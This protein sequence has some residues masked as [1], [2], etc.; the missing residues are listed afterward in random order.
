MNRYRHA[1]YHRMKNLIFYLS[2][3]AKVL[4][5]FLFFL[6]TLGAYSQTCEVTL[7]NDSLI[8]ANNLIVDIYLKATS[9]PFYY[10]SGQFKVKYNKTSILNGGSISGSI[11]PGYSELTNSSQIPTTIYTT[12]S[13]YWRIT[14]EANPTTQAA[15]SQISNL[16]NGTRICRVQL[17]NTAS[18]GAYT[19]NDSLVTTNPY[20]TAIWYAAGDG[21]AVAAT[22]TLVNSN[23]VNPI[24]NGA[25]TVFN[26]TGGGT[27]P[28]AVG[29]DGSQTL[30]VNYILYNGSNPQGS[31]VDGTGS[32][33]SFGNQPV[34]TYTVKA[35]RKATYM[36]QD[37]NGTA[38]VN[39]ACV[40]VTIGT[41]P[42]AKNMCAVTGSASL[43]LTP[44]GSA[45][46]TY[47]WQYYNGATWGNVINGTPAGASYTN[48]TT[49]SLTVSGITNPG[50][51]QYQCFITNCSGVNNATSSAA[52]LTVNPLTVAPTAS[53]GTGA[54]CSQIT[55]N[56]ASSA[57]AT[58]YELDVS[59]S[60][61]FAT[62]VTGYQAL[63]VGNVLTYNVTGLTGG[64]T[65]YYRVRAVN[66]C[67]TSASSNTITYATTP[68]TPAAPAAAAGTGATCSQI[69]A[70]WTASA[71]AL[72]YRLDVSTS[73][74]F[75]TYVT[76]YQD[77]NVLNVV[78][79]NVTGLTGGT[80]YYYRIRAVNACGTSASSSTITYATAPATPA[81]PAANA[82]TGATCSQITANWTASA[83]ALSYRLDV[84]TS[85]TFATYVTGY[86]DLN[87]LNVITYNVTVLIGGTTYYY[88][89]RAVNACGTSA[90]SSTITYATAP[91]T[92][93]APTANAGTG[94]TC[95]QIT[96]NWAASTNATYYELDV[97]TVNTFVTYVTGYQDL[98]V[99]NVLTYN[100]TG[101]T[102][103]TTY[104]YRVRAVNAC[105]TSASSGTI[106]YV[107]APAIPSAPTANAG[108]GAT[109]SQITANWTSSANA[110]YYELDVST[111]NT[112]VTYVTGY[113]DLNVGNVLTYNVTGL[114]GGT[115]YYYR[116]RAVNACGT[117]ANSNVITYAT[118]PG[119][120]VAP[121]ANAGTGATCLQITANWASSA[122]ATSYAL[123]VS[124]VNTFVSYVTG[125]QDLNVGNVLTYN[126]TGLAGG[127]TYYYRVRAINS[128]GNS[129]NSNVITYVTAPSTPAAPVAA[130]GTGATCSQITVNWTASANALSYRLDVSTSNTFVTYVTGYQDLNVLNVI[131][132]NVTGLIGG[133]TYYYRVRAVNACG[134]S[135]S[136]GTITYATAPSTPAAPAAS[137]G[138]G[139]TCS[140]ITAN[141]TSSAN[142][143]SYEL[144]V[145][146]I[147]SFAT[148]VTG[149]Q[150]LNV[151]NV[152]TYNVTGLTGGTTYYYRIRAVNA[153]GT[154]ASSG[155]ITY[156]TTPAIPAAP[157][158][159]AGTGATCL[160]ITANW[161]SSANATYYEL[162]VSTVNTFVTY[163]T[164]YQDLNVGNVVTYNVTGLNGG[165]T[166][167]YR[168]RAVN[169]CGT[170]INSSTIT[171]ATTPGTPAAPVA[172]AGSG[173]TCSQITANWASS[174]NAT[175][176]ALDVSTVNTFVSYVT[177]YQDLNVGNVLTY[178]VTGLTG[179]ITYYYRVRAVN[180][181]GNSVNSNVITYATAPATPTA[182]VANAG[183]GATCSQITAN[184]ASSANATY[185]EL[186]V[187]TVNT[188]AS[189]VTGYQ[190]L[191]VG[192]VVT[193]NVTG[194][195][196]G[197]TYYY[198]VRA[199]NACGTSASSSTITYA[200]APATP[201]AP[202]AIAGS[203]ATCSQI[204]ANWTSSANATSYEL[205]VSTSNTFATYVTGYQDLNVGNVV[206]YNV[207]GLTGSTTY[208]YRV[209]A[210]NA[211]GTSTS[212]STIT[213]ATAPATPAAP[214]ANAG[215]GATCS[216]I[217]ANW[218]SSANATSYE[219]DVSTSNTFATY[220]T[221]YQD[222]NVLN[223]ITYNVTGLTGGTT[224]YYRVRAVN[225]CGTSSN[226]NV[227][228]YATT[229]GTPSQPGT[230]TGTATQC[231]G[232]TSQ[233]YSISP[234]TG[235]TTYTWTVPTGWSI[236]GGTGTTSITVT[237][238]TAGQNGNISVTADN[239]CGTS[240]PRTLG[241]TVS[242][243]TPTQPGTITGT[244]T[245]CPGLTSQVYSISAVTNATTYTWT[246]PTGWSV[247]AGTGTTSITV[248]TGTAG[249][250]GNISVTAG[251][252]CGTSAARTLGVTVSAGTPAQPG[253]ITGITE[254]CPGLTGQAY[255]IS[256]VTGATTYAW[257]VPTGWSITTGAGTTSI[258]VT[259]GST[260]QNGSISVTAGNSCGTS[261]ANT[262]AV[263]V[264]TLSTAPAGVAITNNNTCNG[265][266]KILT[267]AGGNL[268]F[269]A[270]WQWFT[271]SCGG[272][273]AGTGSSIIVDPPAGTST[274]Y[275]V[276][277]SGSCNNTVC[278]SG[279]VVTNPAVGTP[280]T[281][282]PSAT[283][284]CQGSANTNYTS[285]AINAT[286]YN[287]SVTGTGNT[288]S[289]IGTTGTVTWAPGFYG[290][291][292]VSVTANG[293]NGPSS[294]AS[295]T[296]TV[297]QN[298]SA[299]TGSAAQTFCSG[300]LPT[301]AFLTATGT[302]IKW[303]LSSEDG[304]ALSSST[305][306]ATG[307]YYASQTV[308][309]CES[310]SRLAVS[311]TV[312]TT[313]AAPTVGTIT[314]TT[315]ISSTGSVVLSG[316]PSG[317]WTINPG[318][319]TGNTAGTTINNLL[320]GTYNFTVTTNPANCTS[321]ATSNVV[322]N[323]QPVT[324]TPPIVGTITQP[325]C[326]L[327]TG[328]VVLSGLPSSGT[329]TLIRYSGTV[330]TSG[331]G[332]SVSISEL[333]SGSV[334][335]SYNYT[336]TNAAGCTSSLSGNVD[337]N[338]QPPLPSAPV[339]TV[340]CS[341]GYGNAIVTVTS[342]TGSYQYRLDA[343]AFQT[344]TSFTGV[345]NGNHTI[346]VKNSSGCTT[347]GNLFSVSC[348]CANPPAVAL[349]S[350]SGSTCGIT[351]VTVSG[352]TF[353]GGATSVTITEDGSGS[354]SPASATT[355]P[356]NFTYTPVAADAGKVVTITVTTD[357]P[358]GTPCTV[359]T[360]TYKLTVNAIPSA[361]AIGTITQP[362]CNV[363]TGSVVLNGLPSTGT[364]TLTRT[365]GGT[366]TGTGT[367]TTV[368][369]LAA[370]TTYT[371]TVTSAANCTSPVSA[372]VVINPQPETPAPPVVGTI[373]HP[374]C[375]LSTG[376]VV[377]SGLPAGNWKLTRNPGGVT[378][379]SSGSSYNVSGLLS[380]TYTF[381]VT[382]AATCTSVASDEV[383]INAQPETP[384]PPVLGTIVHP[385]CTVATGSVTLTGLPLGTWTL[386]RYPGTITS[387][388]EGTSTTITGL[389]A[390][391]SSNYTV[392]NSSG[393]TSLPSSN[394]IINAQPATP[395]APVVGTITHP[396]FAVPSGSVVLSGLPSSGTW[397]LTR[398]PDGVITTGTG[399]SKTITGIAPGTYTFTVTNAVFCTS[400]PS[401]NVVINAI[402]G[403]PVIVITDPAPVCS[404]S[405][406]DLTASEVTAG[407]A[408]N[409]TFT[410][411]TDE[412]ATIPY[413]TPSAAAAGTYYIKGTTTAG[414]FTIKPVTV[415]VFQLPVPNAGPDQVLE[416][417][418]QTT[419]DAE[420]VVEGTG[421]WSLV[422]G[423]G[424]FSDANDAATNVTGLKSGRND[425]RWTVNNGV[426]PDVSDDVTI[427]VN[428]LLI[429][430]L[431]T[432]NGDPYNEY[433][434]LRGLETLG[435]TE[436][437]IFDRRGAQVY[438]NMNY[439]NTW[440]GLD[441]NG[442][443]LP[444]DTYFYVMKSQNGK[445]LS[446]YIVIRR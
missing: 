260:G 4:F 368:S 270:N 257:T 361:P 217:T 162:D 379:N 130:A 261:A 333:P 439:D 284:I 90:N 299:P 8:D 136:S 382:N 240:T 65:Y 249:Q 28:A 197:T 167:Y 36:Y 138:S 186:D 95:S 2:A 129:V 131:T 367:S 443:E 248:T 184:W 326:T 43:S 318:S 101:L 62:Y 229:P 106:T 247:T 237:T 114:N 111:V 373:T 340:D 157:T 306:L 145:S 170:S 195:T 387:T 269:G 35:H 155:T 241:V 234:V 445:S 173:A 221:G 223:V 149:Y 22:M 311:V 16:G 13:T 429:P 122:S 280:V 268:G 47:Q 272:T 385:T 201:A 415:T 165:T 56:W 121:V 37:M 414:Y 196:G 89:V 266:A 50:S 231:P 335:I 102:G 264:N 168:V 226:S 52:T 183:S 118:T 376:K 239:S 153:C 10:S 294:P 84:S 29:L 194:L 375:G 323:A 185:Y 332:T 87:V 174:T 296:V 188:F 67:G 344:S 426:C 178:N 126:V 356:F 321:V 205:D 103:G 92:P 397:T 212:S 304:I 337:I 328:G 298:P 322:I 287:W 80:T 133:T 224:Y 218:A 20:S 416:Y 345:A 134:T 38:T 256:A 32:A 363:A 410:Y 66:A 97:S 166:Y 433:F 141:W 319:I 355:S 243:G 366:T 262:L 54:T 238:G 399:T 117:S 108:T 424:E 383:I 12:A 365:P 444:D 278:A 100:V 210:V 61:S 190:D 163:V 245:Q 17:T 139:A 81:A 30:G 191:N 316:L 275:Y 199:V 288:I 338:P 357:N 151:G 179:G 393:C 341:L 235:A 140:Q 330:T 422:S 313:P 215:T 350:T 204:T 441:S 99:G 60:N 160:Q 18:F 85:N 72:S 23:L 180:S 388:G 290:T 347:T 431:I 19:A 119:T 371:F 413:A 250:N 398:S 78:T 380:G 53:A 159:N 276:R 203:G 263:N 377:L 46:F 390:G 69:T 331:T 146:T 432:P 220:V 308:S 279:I 21:S 115:T 93:A 164:G 172:N 219:L 253:A 267:V 277:A 317:N 372:N 68:A 211:C 396:T 412:A 438:K 419:M 26:V 175:S 258:S 359:A 77:L 70:N 142:A 360:A 427:T 25:L 91:S 11:V 265:I 246:I 407:S 274:T 152:L 423:A 442:N 307:T 434:L 88:R 113:Q 34:G 285:S 15:C 343:G 310:S 346:T 301:V 374:T 339:Q 315:C 351:P 7:R 402:P 254:Q 208:Y 329:W 71:N 353:S 41:Q 391:S 182:P 58:S 378:I 384:T 125:Y 230:I 362:T 94:A 244:A 435:K 213:Y 75:A 228:T 63:N 109:C 156:V 370:S 236:T 446:G 251:N 286:S 404:T 242:P 83:N 48:A 408:D 200:T 128:C 74:T 418:F 198:R 305:A 369:G 381:T 147:N 405:T 324:P 98:N 137:A 255:S 154:S 411:W 406:A 189:Y 300:S 364:W 425:L 403:A 104:Y 394:V 207:T 291:A 273:S 389:A 120:P 55:A 420:P 225:A 327:A 271:G 436:L 417:V 110:T 282:T 44:N 171:Y 51:Y 64:T 150:A 42:S 334:V 6:T 24:L 31:S 325:T 187:S 181:C 202:T 303:Y 222:L 158:A 342:P 5:A 33:I 421:T 132:Y 206:T 135:A 214:T 45:P 401:A 161:T 112:F 105:G 116:V 27:A 281:P 127:T 295:T 302:G 59:T 309:G 400:V 209:R 348:G 428:D 233:V 430:T 40:P 227:I 73:N 123:D 352:N 437:T 312:N 349:S 176:Y 289:G 124:T 39:A 177:G 144:D 107:T 252:S 354:V 395:S 76:G 14:A 336:V 96:A 3:K 283:T 79:Y 1:K 440:N 259:T 232:L 409:L 293:C 143:T 192:N 297:T 292:T 314:Q 386:T 193:Y 148:Y 358:F 82:G 49:A 9:V 320:P 86:Q 169:A 392:T 57:N 216:Q